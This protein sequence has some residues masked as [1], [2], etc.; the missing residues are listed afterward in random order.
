MAFE[1]VS[2]LQDSKIKQINTNQNDT[3]KKVDFSQNASSKQTIQKHFKKKNNK[4]Q[5]KDCTSKNHNQPKNTVKF[6]IKYSSTK[7]KL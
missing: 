4:N 5:A 7:P 6:H 2:L 3:K 1:Q